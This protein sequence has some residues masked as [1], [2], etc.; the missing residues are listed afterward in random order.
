V[1]LSRASAII[2]R[3]LCS[4]MVTAYYILNERCATYQTLEA[5]IGYDDS[6]LNLGCFLILIANGFVVDHVSF[7]K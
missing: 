6:R 1:A 4:S 2:H 5:E 3:Q 7:K